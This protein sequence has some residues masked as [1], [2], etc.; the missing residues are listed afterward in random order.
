MHNLYAKFD[1]ILTIVKD[2]LQEKLDQQGNLRQRGCSPKFSDAEVIAL[3]LLAEVFM[4]DSEN[5]L[6]QMLKRY[7]EEPFN[8]LIDRS[9]YNRRRRALIKLTEQVRRALAKRLTEGENV[10][11][12]DSM[13]IPVCRFVRAKRIRICK[14]NFDTW[15]SYGRSV[16]MQSTFL[17]YKTTLCELKSGY[18]YPF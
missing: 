11:I 8:R 7:R 18:Y 4:I 14:E 17:G 2:S 6:F 9:C 12:I 5:Y 16:S 3:S 10:F 13:P 1:K 15:P